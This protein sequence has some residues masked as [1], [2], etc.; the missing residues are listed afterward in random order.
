MDYQP[1]RKALPP[2]VWEYLEAGLPIRAIARK[3]GLKHHQNLYPT[4][5]RLEK[6]GKVRHL[7]HG[8][9]VNYDYWKSERQS[10]GG[11]LLVMKGGWGAV[12][13]KERGLWE[14][15]KVSAFARIRRFGDWERVKAYCQGKAGNWVFRRG[16]VTLVLRKRTV[17]VVV[18]GLRGDGAGVVSR[19]ALNVALPVLR[20]FEREFG[21]VFGVLEWQGGFHWALDKVV[22]K[23]ILAVAPGLA[24]STHPEQVEIHFEEE[25]RA[26]QELL[27]GGLRA[28]LNDLIR[29]QRERIEALELLVREQAVVLSKV[30]E[31]LK[32]ERKGV[33]V[34]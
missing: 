8:W 13:G 1:S 22:S 32:L 33:G 16:D 17:Q 4:L 12:G 5:K 15:H 29:E 7:P 3:L 34:T 28:D 21:F 6:E 23:P 25:R 11:K 9:V 19:R 20:L 27:S 24:D 30:V 2:T 31:L 14:A 10:E 26:L 18:H